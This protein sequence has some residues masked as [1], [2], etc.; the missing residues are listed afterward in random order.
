MHR[1]ELANH[2][3][4]IKTDKER[5]EVHSN[6]KSN[7]HCR[8]DVDIYFTGVGMIDIPTKKELLSLMEEIRN[9]ANENTLCSA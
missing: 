8:V 3:A 1:K 2:K 9:Q 4:S 6:D 5:I 7:G